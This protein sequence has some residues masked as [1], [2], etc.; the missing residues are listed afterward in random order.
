MAKRDADGSGIQYGSRAPENPAS[1]PHLSFPPESGRR[2]PIEVCTNGFILSLA[3][4]IA[5]N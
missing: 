5:R 3:I 1:S 4:C 2:D